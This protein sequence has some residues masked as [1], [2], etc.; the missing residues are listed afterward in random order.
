MFRKFDLGMTREEAIKIV[1]NI[2]QTDTE[3]EA[4]GILI[5]ELRESDD[6]RIRKEIRNFLI[7][8]EC[9]KEWIDYMG[10]QTKNISIECAA[11]VATKSKG[12]ATEFLKS[13]GIMN[14]D[15]ELAEQYRTEQESEWQK[16]QMKKDVAEGTVTWAIASEEL[17]SSEYDYL[18]LDTHLGK[19]W[20]M[21]R[22]GVRK[23]E[24]YVKLCDLVNGLS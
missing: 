1:R 22:C 6:E 14:N 2:Y 12:A 20:P 4:L 16:S 21:L 19:E 8:M 7:D 17:R 5:P 18:V 11:K 13:S 24:K 9:K 10:E 3:K 15:G 23:G